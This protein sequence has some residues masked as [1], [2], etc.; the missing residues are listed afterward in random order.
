MVAHKNRL[1][2]MEQLCMLI[3]LGLILLIIIILVTLARWNKFQ[4]FIT[5][6]AGLILVI[7]IAMIVTGGIYSWE[8]QTIPTEKVVSSFIQ[9]FNPKLNQKINRIKAEIA[10]ADNKIQQLHSL[11]KTFP[12]Q[13]QMIDQKINQWQTILRQLNQVSNNIYQ[14]V[15][16]AYVA[17]RI[18]E[19]QGENKFSR[20]SQQLLNEANTAL[21]NA[22]ATK[23]IIEQQLYE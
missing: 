13:S 10:N 1:H 6:I 12:N 23:S 20:I 9:D 11:K 7:Y 5:A 17:Y 2:Q 15:E 4:A 19:I 8:N 22:Q 18:D 16:E 3:R 14:K 21:A